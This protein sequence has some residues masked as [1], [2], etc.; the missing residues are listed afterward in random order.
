MFLFGT[1]E[2]RFDPKDILEF[3]EAQKQAER[4]K[5]EEIIPIKKKVKSKTMNID[6]QKKKINLEMN[7]VV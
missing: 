3:V 2:K 4:I 7:R 1:R 5:L 6:F